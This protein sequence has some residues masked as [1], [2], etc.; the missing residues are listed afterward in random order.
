[1]C[2]NISMKLITPTYVDRYGLSKTSPVCVHMESQ[3]KKAL[4]K[5]RPERRL[6]LLL[7]TDMPLILDGKC[8]YFLLVKPGRKYAVISKYALKS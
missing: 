2:L 6:E 3:I 1:M 5:R 4:Y 8:A 7:D